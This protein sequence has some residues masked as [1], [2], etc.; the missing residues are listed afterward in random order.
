MSASATPQDGNSAPGTANSAVT[1][2]RLQRRVSGVYNRFGKRFIDLVLVV[3]MIII[4]APVLLAIAAAVFLTS[5]SPVLYQGERGGLHGKPFR[6]LKFRTMVRNADQVG[7]GTTA[8][9]DARITR[10]G[11][12]LRKTKLDEFPQLFNILRGEMSFIGPRPELLQYTSQY[13][14]LEEYILEVRPGITDFSSLEFMNLAS[15]V[16]SGDADAVYEREVLPR[17]NQL[18]IKYVARLSP[19]TDL[20]LFVHTVL[21]AVQ[22]VMRHVFPGGGSHGDH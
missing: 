1:A 6:I 8:L 7:G 5:G 15:V 14:G 16:G 10:V 20:R 9:G 18:R 4:L 22:G 21:R 17:K 13:S 19:V 3:P 12:V 11:A 2:R